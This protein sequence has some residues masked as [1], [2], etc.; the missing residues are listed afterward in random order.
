MRAGLLFFLFSTTDPAVWFG[1]ENVFGWSWDRLSTNFCRFARR[2]LVIG[3]GFPF[4]AHTSYRFVEILDF[5]PLRLLFG[6]FLSSPVAYVL[7]CH[8]QQLR[9]R[10]L[11]Y[12]CFSDSL[13]RWFSFSKSFERS[14]SLFLKQKDLHVNSISSDCRWFFMILYCLW[15]LRWMRFSTAFYCRG[16]WLWEWLAVISGVLSFTLPEPK[17]WQELSLQKVNCCRVGF[18]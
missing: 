13:Y 16:F 14:C 4:A 12:S 1:G 11:S 8:C 7:L 15:V 3:A 6:V 2:W 10:R 17:E 9:S 5:I 18:R